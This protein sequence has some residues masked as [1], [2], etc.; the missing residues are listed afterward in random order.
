MAFSGTST[1]AAGHSFFSDTILLKRIQTFQ[2]EENQDP[3]KDNAGVFA[4]LE[5]ATV[6]YGQQQLQ[7]MYRA[8]IARDFPDGSV[9]KAIAGLLEGHRERY[10]ALWQRNVQ[11]AF[12]TAASSIPGATQFGTRSLLQRLADFF[13]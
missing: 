5:L 12:A 9:P 4:R 10:L 1:S 7:D 8:L 2:N 6:I 13:L 3:T 11:N